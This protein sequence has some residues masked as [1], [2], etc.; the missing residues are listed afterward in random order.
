MLEAIGIGILIL[1]CSPFIIAAVVG[2]TI[3]FLGTFGVLA[4][5]VTRFIRG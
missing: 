2:L 3:A 1:L 4:A 5:V